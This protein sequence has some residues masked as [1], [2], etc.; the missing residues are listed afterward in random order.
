M[1]A[2]AE[3]ILHYLYMP[4]S[5]TLLQYLLRLATAA[6]LRYPIHRK[7]ILQI[8]VS[9]HLANIISFEPW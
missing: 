2:F 1:I 8:S 5:T 3:S 6:A 9:N 4:P 7:I